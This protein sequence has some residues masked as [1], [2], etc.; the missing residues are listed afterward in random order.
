MRLA[1]ALLT[2][3]ISAA[4]AQAGAWTLHR[5]HWQVF[6][7]TTQSQASTSFDAHGR[8]AIQTNF[9]KLLLQN[10]LEYGLSNSV[11]LFAIPN[12]V[13][14][15][16]QTPTVPLTVAHNASFE[17]GARLMLYARAGKL[18]LQTSYKT[19]GAFDLSVSAN[20]ASGRQIEVRL[21]YGTSFRLFGHDGFADLQVAQRWI[22]HPRPNET[23]LDLTAGLWLTKDSM[24]MAQSFNIVSAGDARAPYTYY[25]S[26]KLELSLVQKLSRH[27][28]LQ[29]GAFFSPAGQNA[30]VEK[31]ITVSLWTQD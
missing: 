22:S 8:A 12:Y 27:W 31:G 10:C 30:L 2:W 23:P 9:S 24:L 4:M 13:T 6:T 25:R 18:S 28:S 17:A 3:T 21:L 5:G 14:A 15:H 7:A 26:H 16:V 1:A 20:R 11:T 29:V 19:A